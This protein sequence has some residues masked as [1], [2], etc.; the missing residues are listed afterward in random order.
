MLEAA[1]PL[2]PAA[3]QGTDRLEREL[4]KI[5]RLRHTAC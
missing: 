5:P 2:S 1:D 3:L 4:D